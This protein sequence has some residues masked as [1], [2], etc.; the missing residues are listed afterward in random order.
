MTRISEF[1]CIVFRIIGTHENF[2][3]WLVSLNKGLRYQI[4]LF[5]SPLVPAAPEIHVA[6][7]QVFDNTVT[8]V[9]TLP[10]ADSK[11]EHY[12][13]EY[14]RTNHDG[15]PRAREDYPWMVVEGIKETEYTLTGTC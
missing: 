6:E 1:P 5:L 4:S 11:I 13:L 7:C 8:V 14:R 15:P 9:W 12:I 3:L 2:R 10:E